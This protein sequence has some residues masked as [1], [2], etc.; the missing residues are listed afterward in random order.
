MTNRFYFEALDKTLRDILQVINPNAL[1]EGVN[2]LI[3]EELRLYPSISDNQ[4]SPKYFEERAILAPT[5][6]EVDKINDFIL[7]LLP[8]DEKVYLSSNSHCKAVQHVDND[9]N[10]YTSYYL[11]TIRCSGVP[12]H[13]SMFWCPKSLKHDSLF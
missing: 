8:G 1:Q 7:S 6:E 5:H 13:V 4:V 9:E 12:N 11:N 2:K 10:V 3:L